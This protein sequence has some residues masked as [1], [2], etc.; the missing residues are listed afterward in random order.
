MT[1]LDAHTHIEMLP[2]GYQRI[3]TILHWEN[4]K[5]TAHCLA[6]AFIPESSERPAVV[7]L[8]EIRTNPNGLGITLDFAGAA[9]ALRENMAGE[10]GDP[11]SIVWI[12]H[13]GTFSS[14]E[15]YPAPD[16]FIRVYLRHKR[17]VYIDDLSFHEKIGNEEIPSDV[18]ESLDPV[19]ET[20]E[21][22]SWEKAA[23][24]QW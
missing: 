21:K 20:L 11:E 3:E 15:Y 17:N 18:L 14:Y 2:S 13:Y 9:M 4:V 12:A 5:G 24:F 16:E 23:S 8:S 6:R 10:L 7:I 1:N 22:L 19:P